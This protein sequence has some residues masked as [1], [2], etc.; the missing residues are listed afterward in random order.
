MRFRIRN[1]QEYSTLVQ[2]LPLYYYYEDSYNE[3]EENAEFDSSVD[4]YVKRPDV[5]IYDKA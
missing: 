5:N 2:S 3:V 4:Y 1:V